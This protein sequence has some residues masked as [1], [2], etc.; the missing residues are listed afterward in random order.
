MRQFIVATVAIILAATSAWADEEMLMSFTTKSGKEM[1][2]NVNINALASGQIGFVDFEGNTLIINKLSQLGPSWVGEVEG[3]EGSSAVFTRY[4][5]Q[6][7]GLISYN[8]ITLE[9]SPGER[10]QY[11]V[12]LIT[13]EDLPEIYDFVLETEEDLANLEAVHSAADDAP[14]FDQRVQQDILI[15]YT[16]A[17]R[18]HY[19]SNSATES[20]ILNAVAN[21]NQAYINSDINVFL[22]VVH[23]YEIDYVES[24]D[25][26]TD[27]SRFRGTTD[28][29]M[30][31]V[32][33]RRDQYGADL[34]HLITNTGNACGVAYI[35]N[36][37]GL[38]RRSCFGQHT[39][40]HEVGHNQGSSH[41]KE[42]AS[43]A[44]TPY[45]YGYR[46][47]ESVDGFRT[48]MSYS[49]SG[50]G[51]INWFSNPNKMYRTVHPMGIHNEADNA[52]SINE[53]ARSVA[54][55]RTPPAEIYPP[56]APS[57]LSIQSISS[58]SVS[59]RWRDNSDNETNFVVE[60]RTDNGAWSTVATVGANT[61]SF[62]NSG[63]QP[64]TSYS[65]R[66]YAINSLYTSSTSNEVT[67]TTPEEQVKGKPG[68]GGGGGKPP[69]DDEKPGGGPKK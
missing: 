51:R 36:A 7:T 38:T 44:R 29:F 2:G 33:Q 30:D 10:G 68:K 63:L 5:G 49:C 62:N 48:V 40:A 59:L 61:T 31:D 53:T 56:N 60:R 20:A 1:T 32:H 8:N 13:E 22:N 15:A 6:L 52:R 23:M 47:C 12:R 42:N 11:I 9:L 65:W 41:N 14:L 4:R 26:T 28:G 16:P 35:F 21:A 66:V 37:F 45:S 50:A 58:N 55:W 43:S 3:Y 34:V 64:L 24:G 57:D 69:K 18:A 19:G 46:R 39:F 27:V 17:V 67:A 54:G 25:I